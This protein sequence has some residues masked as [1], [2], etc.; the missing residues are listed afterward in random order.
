MGMMLSVHPI[1][2]ATL[3]ALAAVGGAGYMGIRE[4]RRRE[5]LAARAD[6]E[7]RQLMGASV[8][9]VRPLPQRQAHS[10]PWQAVRLLRTEP[11]R[12]ARGRR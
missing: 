3:I 2:A 6:Y 4:R 7:N 9:T 1:A 12:T 11:L 5:A 8:S 10:L